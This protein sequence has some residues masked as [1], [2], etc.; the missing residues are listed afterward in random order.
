MPTWRCPARCKVGLRNEIVAAKLP[1]FDDCAII[2]RFYLSAAGFGNMPFRVAST[3]DSLLSASV[4]SPE[5]G[6]RAVE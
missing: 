6:M 2:R 5:S 4:G 3:I 1:F